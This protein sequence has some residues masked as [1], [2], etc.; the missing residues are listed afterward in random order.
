[1][2][3]AGYATFP[4]SGGSGGPA[5][6]GSITGILSNQ[7]DLYAALDEKLNK[8]GGT[9][10]GTIVLNNLSAS[11]VL[12]TNG[13]K[14][15]IS[16]SKGT[17]Y[18]KNFGTVAGT[19]LEGSNDALY[20]KL[21]S[22]NAFSTSGT[23]RFGNGAFSSDNSAILVSRA[24]SAASIQGHAVRDEGT[25][26]SL[27]NGDGYCS[28]D[29]NYTTSGTSDYNH[30]ACF[31]ARSIYS[32]SG[33]MQEW[34]GFWSAFIHSGTGVVSNVKQLHATNPGG[35]G[36]IT[37]LYG[38]F[39][40]DLTRGTNNHPIY[41][42]SSAASLI[43]GQW[44]IGKDSTAN[45]NGLTD[46]HL[47]IRGYGPAGNKQF[48]FGYHTTNNYAW[49]QAANFG[50]AYSAIALN[51]N[52]GNVSIGTATTANITA[53]LTLSGGTLSRAPLRFL[54]GVAPSVLDDGIVWYD[55]TDV[56]MRI[57]G[58]TKTFSFLP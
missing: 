43:S 45:G 34:R 2:G 1:M 24:L 11:S 37:D 51:P 23:N 44:Q 54:P 10:T 57:G 12:E 20:P 36:P 26:N 9:I 16:A 49:I 4:S 6:W 30:Q 42:L 33:S 38:L 58:V 5:A 35:A 3:K 18:N 25:V 55:G 47:S 52:G 46:G 7:A 17:A 8:T 56:K 53:L 21:A 27:A 40:D 28:F 14:E 39:I 19:V 22:Q 31:Q 41:S 48:N 13:T 50:I 29:S 15:L 32:G